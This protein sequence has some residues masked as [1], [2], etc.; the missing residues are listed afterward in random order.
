MRNIEAISEV[1][2]MT[3]TSLGPNG[4]NK[5]IINHIDKLILTKDSG[6]MM[7][8]LDVNHPAARLIVHAIK[9]QVEEQGDSTNFI[10]TFAGEL[11]QLAQTLIQSGLHPADILYGYDL[12]FKKTL[13]LMDTLPKIKLNDL[14]SQS[15]VSKFLAPV[16]GTKVLQGQEYIL[17][18]LIAEA[19]IR[20][21]PTNQKS[22]NSENVR[23][24]KMLGGSLSDSS[25][26]NG[27]VVVRLCEGSITKVGAC[28]VAVYNCPLDA[29]ESETKDTVLFKNSTEL[30]NYTKSEEANMEKVIQS[31]CNAGVRC[32]FVGG[33]VSNM[34]IHY[35]DHYKIMCVRIMSKFEIRRIAKS[36]GA[37]MLVR[38]GA[39]TPEEMGNADKVYVDE[40]GSQKCIIVEKQ[41]DENKLATV[42]LRGST[43]NI[44]EN[45]ERVIESGVNAYRSFCNDNEFIPGA[46]AS[47]MVK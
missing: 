40:I 16:I 27:L 7:R 34:A 5:F 21:L 31:I 13:E 11:M 33:S 15:E 23:V 8:E 24:C 17:A 46:G 32:V 47:E 20:V 12:A 14:K 4:M 1:M 22:F 35:L 2:Q 36:L 39:P 44:I 28:K 25:V 41:S 3:R 6:V 18:P 45:M 19:C 38:L 30:L 26:I 9:M 29:T 10:V 43:N 42:L 37:T